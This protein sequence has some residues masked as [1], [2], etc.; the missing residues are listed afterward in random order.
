MKYNGVSTTLNGG[1]SVYA[2][3]AWLPLLRGYFG[4]R[5]T[6][7][8][9][10]YFDC[11]VPVELSNF[12]GNIRNNVIDLYWETS[13]EVNND[14]F[15]V[16]RREVNENKTSEWNK[17]SFVKGQ[18]NSSYTSNYNYS[19]ANV[20]LG[21]TY[22]YRLR[23]V[24]FDNTLSCDDFSKVLTFTV[25]SNEDIALTQNTPNP[26]NDNTKFKVTLNK[27]SSID[28]EIVDIYGN[29]V[30]NIFKGEL[31]ANTYDNFGWNGANNNGDK[32][33]NGVYF[34]RLTSGD[35]VKTIKMTYIQ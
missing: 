15:N 14:G 23:S 16:E 3:T 10:E 31:S 2:R 7:Q 11:A 28:L 27:T 24:D 19:D 29:V 20:V 9:S 18:G 33:S 22:Q 8:V 32:V 1:L 21:K 5:Q 4:Q 13:S 35:N 6:D 34:L 17:V 25:N 12:N 30:K 26:F